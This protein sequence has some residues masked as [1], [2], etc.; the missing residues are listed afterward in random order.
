MGSAT[1]QVVNYKNM[2]R[3]TARWAQLCM[4]RAFAQWR[5]VS[6]YSSE[7]MEQLFERPN[8]QAIL[9]RVKMYALQ[10][11]WER[12]RENYDMNAGIRRR[13]EERIAEDER[14]KIENEELK[15][16]I[17][18]LKEEILELKR[19]RM[20]DVKRNA[21]KEDLARAEI[22][23]LMRVQEKLQ[24]AEKSALAGFENERKRYEREILELQNEFDRAEKAHKEG[25]SR[26]GYG[27]A[28]SCGKGAQGGPLT[29][30]DRAE[31]AHK[32][33]LEKEREAA[34]E[35]LHDALSNS[36]GQVANMVKELD[37][38]LAAIERLRTTQGQHKVRRLQSSLVLATFAAWFHRSRRKNK[39]GLLIS[40][41]LKRAEHRW[42]DAML[43]HWWQM[44]KFHKTVSNRIQRFQAHCRRGVLK[45]TL[46]TWVAFCTGMFNER[47]GERAAKLLEAQLNGRAEKC[48]RGI[49]TRR[50]VLSL[51]YRARDRKRSV[52]RQRH[53]SRILQWHKVL[54][55][56]R[57]FRSALNYRRETCLYKDFTL[58]KFRKRAEVWAKAAT[59]EWLAKYAAGRCLRRS[60]LGMLRARSTRRTLQRAL[61]GWEDGAHQLKAEKEEALLKCLAMAEEE[62]RRRQ[63]EQAAELQEERDGARGNLLY[64]RYWARQT[65]RT[66]R[67]LQRHLACV[68]YEQHQAARMK[69]KKLVM[70][71]W[72]WTDVI[73]SRRG[74][75]LLQKT[76]LQRYWN[77]RRWQMRWDVTKQWRQSIVWKRARQEKLARALA[78]LA[79]RVQRGALEA[80]LGFLREIQMVEEMKLER[81]M[82]FRHDKVMRFKRRML[83][84]WKVVRMEEK[85]EK[86]HNDAMVFERGQRIIRRLHRMFVY[87]YWHHWKAMKMTW[88]FRRNALENAIGKI[89][90]YVMKRCFYLWVLRKNFKMQIKLR[91]AKAVRIIQRQKSA[92]Y[93]RVWNAYVG[94]QPAACAAQ[95]TCS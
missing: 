56:F 70:L 37:K 72:L 62:E 83:A 59:M 13:Q 76:S 91:M 89:K 30:G 53:I 84:G 49:Y 27:V 81:A 48:M 77:R 5:A 67:E 54:V 19:Q 34:E 7:Q 43:E 63:E 29:T 93:L 57:V 1:A 16:T 75:R 40:M 73:S 26:Q 10:A 66:F 52:R 94:H 35:R 46:D 42:V 6:D 15:K 55:A 36:E 9:A 68:H 61:L 18:K 90:R 80:W 44:A 14:S 47:K 31:K 41:M 28:G 8:V 2:A 86:E 17:E 82:K 50:V 95:H 23:S 11:A 25:P 4:Y 32:E 39:Q 60:R 74:K 21:E 71:L 51:W 3:F 87:D 24:E 20:H 78:A 88:I 92:A 33:G 65:R 64:G 12:W 69:R 45:D 85:Q 38:K 58:V 79:K 22:D